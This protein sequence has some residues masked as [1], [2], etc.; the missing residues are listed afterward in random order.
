MDKHR[1]TRAHKEILPKKIFLKTWQEAVGTCR[2]LRTSE[3]EIAIVLSLANGQ[4]IEVFFP[5]AS[6][7]DV[8]RELDDRMIGRKIGIMKVD[9][10]ENPILIRRLD[11]RV[12]VPEESSVV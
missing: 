10:V 8:L 3:T 5:R 2:G 12:R 11:E 4:I 1:Y 9:D 6:V 7:E